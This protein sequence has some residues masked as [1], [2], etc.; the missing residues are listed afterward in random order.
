MIGIEHLHILEGSKNQT[1]ERQKILDWICSSKADYADQQNA[2]R[3]R[4]QIGIG[5]WFLQ[6]DEFNDWNI[7]NRATL[8]CSGMPGVGKTMITS[9]VVSSILERY[10]ND[11]ETGLVYIYCQFSRYKQQTPDYLKSSI[12]RQLLERHTVIPDEVRSL[13]MSRKGEDDLTSD[14]V[15]NLLDFM[16]GLFKKS[17][18][19][20]D[21]LDELRSA[22]CREVASDVFAFQQKFNVNVYATSR[23]IDDIAQEAPNAIQVS[24][25]AREEDL[26]CSLEMVLSRGYLLSKRPDLQQ[27]AISKILQVTDGM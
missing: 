24:I 27:R 16:L 19:V 21:A 9:F 26:R 12:L 20:I 5:E 7:G 15:S 22:T 3:K 1:L 2:L 4:R 8:L 6:S 25:R 10:I 23:Y 13:Y 11:T 14:E 17:V 18:F